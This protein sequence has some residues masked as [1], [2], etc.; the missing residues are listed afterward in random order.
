MARIMTC[1]RRGSRHFHKGKEFFF[2]EKKTDFKTICLKK[3]PKIQ[4]CDSKRKLQHMVK[5]NDWDGLGNI[6]LKH[7]FTSL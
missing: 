4:R 7:V 3:N 5:K 1:S 6:L 2:I